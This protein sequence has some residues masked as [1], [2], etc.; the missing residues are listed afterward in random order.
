MSDVFVIRNQL[1]HYWG[2]SKAWIDGRD[3]RAAQRLKHQDEAVNLLFELSS[4][5]VD[6]RGEVVTAAVDDRGEPLLEPSNNPLPQPT[7]PDEPNVA[8]GTE[9]EALVDGQTGA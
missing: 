1:G 2:K 7:A 8:A 6:L 3:A 9:H 4:K 5:D